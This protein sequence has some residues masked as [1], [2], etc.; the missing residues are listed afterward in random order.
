VGIMTGQYLQDG[1]GFFEP[2]LN[3]QQPSGN[4]TD[5]LQCLSSFVNK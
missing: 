2:V 4:S 5:N 3:V 1:E